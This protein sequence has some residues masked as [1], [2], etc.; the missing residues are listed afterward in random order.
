M[1]EVG[2]TVVKKVKKDKKDKPTQ[3][4]SAPYLPNMYK[5]KSVYNDFTIKKHIGGKNTQH[6]S[7][8]NTK[9]IEDKT[10]E[11]DYQIPTVSHTFKIKLQEARR[12]KNLTQKQLAVLC[13][14]Q[15]SV[16][17]NYEQGTIVPN[18]QDIVKMNRALG[19][20]L[21]K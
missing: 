21:G 15:E 1:S 4:Q 6:Y 9:K 20:T 8:N 7:N 13:N 17:K 11:G 12:N 10:D 14:M 3:S 19:V 16:I 2:W 5:D 18:P